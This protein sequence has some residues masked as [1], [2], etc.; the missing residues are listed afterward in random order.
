MVPLTEHHRK[1]GVVPEV[2]VIDLAGNG[3]S[4]RSPNVGPSVD[5]GDGNKRR[6]GW[7]NQG[8]DDAFLM[9]DLNHNGRVDSMYELLGGRGPSRAF[10]FLEATS[11]GPGPPDDLIN[12][13]NKLFQRLVLWTDVN[14]DGRSSEPE[15]QSAEY[16]GLESISRKRVDLR[17]DV[18][19]GGQALEVY[20]AQKRTING[21]SSV[22][23]VAVRLKASRD[24]IP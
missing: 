7:V 14:A 17:P 22:Q 10:A 19:P 24:K 12:A 6:S 16:A 21:L 3:I 8:T 20:L 18:G 11:A 2:L 9:F 4:F 5:F 1:D 23:V 15:L 13:S